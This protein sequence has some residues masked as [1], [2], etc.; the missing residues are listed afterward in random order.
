[1]GSLSLL[2]GTDSK[3]ASGTSTILSIRFLIK[4]KNVLRFGSKM[5]NQRIEELTKLRKI[6]QSPL[7]STTR[8]RPGEKRNWATESTHNLKQNS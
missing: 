7:A 3:L 6:A 8:S 1:M 2:S 4:M 5:K